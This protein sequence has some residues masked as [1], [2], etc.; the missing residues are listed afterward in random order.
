MKRPIYLD[1]AA[2][3]PVDPQVAE[4]M[5]ECLTFDGTFGNAASRSHAYGWQAEEKVE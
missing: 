3:T 1:Y 4:R 5:M 2:T